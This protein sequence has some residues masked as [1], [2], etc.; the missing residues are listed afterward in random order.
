MNKKINVSFPGGKKVNALIG[1]YA[2]ETDQP[3]SKGGSGAAPNPFQLFLASIALCAG[4]FALEFCQV[5]NIVAEDMS[6]DMDC[7]FDE[8][9]KLFTAINIRLK[10]PEGFPDKYKNAIVNAMNACTVKKHILNPPEFR[11]TASLE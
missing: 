7:E 8:E 1:D 5:R 2:I 11:I 4:F 6:L 3:T 9:K 10:L